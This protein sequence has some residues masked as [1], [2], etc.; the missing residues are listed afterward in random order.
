MPHKNLRNGHTTTKDKSSFQGFPF[1]EQ[2]DISKLDI[3]FDTVNE[4]LENKNHNS[5][6][7]KIE[8][9]DKKVK[10]YKD[11]LYIDDKYSLDSIL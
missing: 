11:T 1:V 4:F 5:I 2:K 6:K 3:S 7:A 10:N 8:T 9:I